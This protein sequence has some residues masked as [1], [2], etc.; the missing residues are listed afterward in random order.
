MP[1]REEEDDYEASGAVVPW[2]P[3]WVGSSRK[4]KRKGAHHGFAN[5][6]ADHYHR[7]PVSIDGYISNWGYSPFSD[8]IFK[9]NVTS[10]GV[11]VVKFWNYSY[12]MGL[13]VNAPRADMTVGALPDAWHM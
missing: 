13:Y 7:Y 12:I 1:F 2:C 10:V 11:C 5:G 4:R 8:P 3:S 9:S 6:F